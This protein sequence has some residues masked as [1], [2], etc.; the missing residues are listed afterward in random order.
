MK[1]KLVLF[2]S[3]LLVTGLSL[4]AIQTY[5]DVKAQRDVKAAA[6]QKQRNDT[7]NAQQA[8]QDKS[9]ARINELFNECQKGN[10][11][12]IKARSISRLN[13]GLVPLQ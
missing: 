7:K 1:N 13:C 12:L 4:V 8:Y 6:I 5:N 11:E 3:L 2:A 9:T 10:V